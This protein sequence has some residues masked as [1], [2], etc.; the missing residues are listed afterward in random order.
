MNVLWTDLEGSGAGLAGPVA[1]Q[2]PLDPTKR[3]G[4]PPQPYGQRSRFETA[5]RTIFAPKRE[6]EAASFTPLQDLHGIITPS[7]L[8][9]T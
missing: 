6:T 3:Q 5:A 8:H 9:Y 7:S 2:S 4:K 1:D